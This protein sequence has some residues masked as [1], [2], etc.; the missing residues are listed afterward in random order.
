MPSYTQ[1]NNAK[2]FTNEK[3][4]K[5]FPFWRERGTASLW[6]VVESRILYVKKQESVLMFRQSV[7]RKVNTALSEHGK[8]CRTLLLS[9]EKGRTI[10]DGG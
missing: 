10:E 5:R 8:V 6:L 2:S 4:A 3:H 9:G 7:R 1:G